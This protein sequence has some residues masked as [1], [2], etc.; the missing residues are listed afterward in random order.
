MPT[1]TFRCPNGH[2]FDRRVSRDTYQ[3]TSDAYCGCVATARRQEVYAINFGGFART[4]PKERDWS[5]DFKSYQE[6]SHEIDY[7]HSRIEEGV[8][9]ALPNP[10][11]FKAAKKRAQALMAKGAVD[12]NDL[13]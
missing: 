10:P 13:S 7:K 11:L 3:V 9:K 4:P 12:A 5:S 2:E 8:G 6:A 1:Y